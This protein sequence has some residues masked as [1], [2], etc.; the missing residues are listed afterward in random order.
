MFAWLRR[1]SPSLPPPSEPTRPE[2]VDELLEASRK[3]ARTSAKQAARSEGLLEQ[4]S[5]EL[6]AL[7]QAVS[8]LNASAK[9]DEPDYTE[10]FDALDGLD[11]AQGL[12]AEPALSEGLSLVARRI[13]RFCA[14]QGY[15]RSVT[16][17]QKP[18]A[19]WVRVVGVEPSAMAAGCITRT[20]R[21]AVLCGDRVV[22]EGEVIVSG[23]EMSD[24]QRL[25]N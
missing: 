1:R 15:A 4:T 23:G 21:A 20:V 3:Q 2:W 8:K 14:R 12:C 19:D 16:P 5:Q 18:R 11:M 7:T 13:E 24:D 10:L 25:G 17:G 6:V 9:R 22:R